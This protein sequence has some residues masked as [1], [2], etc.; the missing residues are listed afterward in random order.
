MWQSDRVWFLLVTIAFLEV[1]LF[2]GYQFYASLTG[3]STD[4]VK[5][6]SD[7]PLPAELGL[8]RLQDIDSLK[9]KILVRNDDLN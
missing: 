3:Q 9:S 8:E 7:A 1:I 5:R 6:V 2:I 4:L